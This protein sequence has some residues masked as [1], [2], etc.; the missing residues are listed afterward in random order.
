MNK[1][2]APALLILIGLVI[3][4][5]VLRAGFVWDDRALVLADPLIRS[6]RL[7]WEGFQHF[8]FTDA[9][10]SEFYRPLQRVTYLVDY[11]AFV[12]S[13]GGYHLMSVLWH[14]A[15]AVALFFLGDELLGFCG[16]ETPRRS[17][18]AFLAAL[19]WLVHPLQSAAVA[20]VSGRADPLAAAFG[21]TALFLGLRMLRATGARKWWLGFGVGLCLLAS[22]LSKEMGLLFLLLWLVLVFAQKRRSEIFGALGIVLAVLVIYLSLRLPAEHPPAPAERHPAP[23]LVRPIVVARA[24]A[25][26][27]GLLVFPLHLHMDRDVETRPSGFVDAEP[28]PGGVA[29]TPDH[30]RFGVDRSGGMGALARAQA[31]GSFASAPA[32]GA[33]LFAD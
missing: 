5:P 3:Y 28:R 6:W 19:A 2:V 4:A 22:A 18:L 10:G 12:F 29:G 13:P 21:F 16:M 31:P 24:A 8:L 7:L 20:Y 23:L 33:Q 11:A 25:E 1:K 32:R 9:G 30:S 14:A 17:W 15:A 27:A 26:Y